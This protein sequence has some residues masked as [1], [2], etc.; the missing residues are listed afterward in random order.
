MRPGDATD[1]KTR[2][3]GQG[4]SDDSR[5]R[6]VPVPATPAEGPLLGSTSVSVSWEEEG[7]SFPTPRRDPDART[8]QSS[9]GEGTGV[10]VLQVKDV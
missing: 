2:T 5:L 4:S 6:L 10:G 1:S 3:R 8:P 7:R 9:A